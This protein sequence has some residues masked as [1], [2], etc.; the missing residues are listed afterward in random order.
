MDAKIDSPTDVSW[1]MWESRKHKSEK[2]GDGSYHLILAIVDG[3]L[4]GLPMIILQQF[5]IDIDLE[6]LSVK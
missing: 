2:N 1:F 4:L 5:N 3:L 6:N